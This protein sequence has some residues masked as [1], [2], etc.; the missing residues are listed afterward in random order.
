MGWR[1]IDD[2]RQRLNELLEQYVALDAELRQLEDTEFRICIFGSARIRPEDPTYQTVYRLAKSL[3]ELGVDI[4]T[5]GGP[6]LMEAA[7]R[8]VQEAKNEQ[9]K[10]Y[11]LPIELPRGIET[12]NKHLDIKSQHKRFSSRLDEFMRLSHAV[13]VAP[14]GIGTVLELM[15]VWQLLQVGMIEPRPVI[16]LGREFWS[17]FIAWMRD[18]QLQKGFISP[19]DLDHVHL[20]DSPKE[21]VAIIRSA[22]AAYQ[23][24]LRPAVE[25]MPEDDRVKA[26]GSLMRAAVEEA[27]VA[28]PEA[29]SAAAPE[30]EHVRDS[31]EENGGSASGPAIDGDG[32]TADN[33]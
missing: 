21:V 23:E 20:V 6:G 26:V 31:G 7:N 32:G 14:G 22:L 17:G 27:T 16:L 12:P 4:I 29:I 5:G 13:V 18:Q 28:A 30:A 19:Q 15:Y 3:A 9:S 11:G 1:M 8:G 25:A 33:V 24:R 2:V 10:S